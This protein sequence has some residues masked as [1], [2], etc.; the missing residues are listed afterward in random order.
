[1]SNIFDVENPDVKNAKP[2]NGIHKYVSA[3]RLKVMVGNAFI[4][5]LILNNWR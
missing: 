1:M 2:Q 5:K 3:K 4:R